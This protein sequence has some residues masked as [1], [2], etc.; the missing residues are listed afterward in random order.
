MSADS[1]HLFNFDEGTVWWDDIRVHGVY[2]G[3]QS[4]ALQTEY[5]RT[6]SEPLME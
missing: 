6:E 5:Y 2:S 4:S 1:I 3:L